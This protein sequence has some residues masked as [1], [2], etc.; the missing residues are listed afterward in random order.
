MNRIDQPLEESTALRVV[1][2]E[3]LPAA[4]PVNPMALLQQAI[5]SNVDV[6]KLEKLLDLQQRWE[7]SRAAEMFAQAMVR[8]QARMPR[9]VRDRD[10]PHT[11][12]R[13]A[14]LETIQDRIKPIYSDDGFSVTFSEGTPAQAG[15]VR[16]V[17][18]VR[19]SSGHAETHFRDG[20]VDNLGPKGNPTK[21]VLHGAASTFTYMSRQLLC[22]IFNITIA[23]KDD[24][25]NAGS[26]Y[27]PTITEEQA[28]QLR[29]MIDQSGSK[30][31]LFLKWARVS[32]L[33]DMPATMF[34]TALS[35][36]K[37]KLEGGR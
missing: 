12:S 32:R 6:A 24:D 13:F 34:P 37:K 28:I 25:G 2:R 11:N 4:P 26:G 30:M 8:T 21:S 14:S 10:N 27:G 3:N 33:E 36:L 29:E 7:Q 1:D 17:A 31:D 15:W 9:V 19:H 35:T 22:G 20:P 5:E 23:N 18:V 16:V